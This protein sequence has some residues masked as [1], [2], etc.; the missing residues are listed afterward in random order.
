[1]EP[2]PARFAAAISKGEISLVTRWQSAK[3]ILSASSFNS[4]SSKGRNAS[5]V[6]HGLVQIKMQWRRL[7]QPDIGVPAMIYIRIY[8]SGIIKIFSECPVC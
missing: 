6:R 7:E 4:L 1:M 5:R 3:R 8:S 2:I